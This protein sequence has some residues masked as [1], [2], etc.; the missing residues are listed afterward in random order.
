MR[1]RTLRP[2]E[3]GALL[4][5]LDGWEGLPDG[6]RGRELFRRYIE[7]DPRF[8]DRDVVVAEDSGRLVSCVQIFARHARIGSAQVAMGGIGSV[9]T[10]PEMRGSGVASA[11]LERSIEAMRERGMRFSLLFAARLAFYG[12]LGWES[13]TGE[14]WLLR[15]PE[16]AAMTQDEAGALA[17]HDEIEIVDLDAG[18][19]LDAVRALHASYSGGL[20]GTLWRDERDW[21]ASLQVGGNPGEEFLLARHDGE[22][23]A[24]V[25]AIVLS[26]F[27]V[28]SELA[29]RE[30]ERGVRALV[31][32]LRRLLTPRAHDPIAPRD[33]PSETLRRLAAAPRLP[34]RALADA[35]ARAGVAI[36]PLPD[37][38]AMLRCL[39]APGLAR[40]LGLP[41]RPDETPNALLR[42]ALPPERFVFWPADRF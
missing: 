41:L 40:D 12:R 6:A 10:R 37:P 15:A 36:T 26:G 4:D 31:A 27:L 20:D 29:R 14:R 30:G 13:W 42:R 33:R 11:V 32:L 1:V 9:F 28:V 22:P 34:D 19:D 23:V 24:Y 2:D 35:L 16:P 18:R 7:I 39:D 5:L 17:A 25:R 38:S 3:R 21:R 8:E